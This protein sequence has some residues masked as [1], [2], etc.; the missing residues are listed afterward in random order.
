MDI[1]TEEQLSKLER[2]ATIVSPFNAKKLTDVL[3]REVEED[4]YLNQE[5]FKGK[6]APCLARGIAILKEAG[7]TI[8][9]DK[10]VMM[11][12]VIAVHRGNTHSEDT[13]AEVEMSTS[14]MT[15]EQTETLSTQAWWH[16]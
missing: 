14:M 12:Y 7:D 9:P 5:D 13:T 15:V 8:T 2:L 4:S 3:V 6:A 16:G 1:I 10:A 11:Q